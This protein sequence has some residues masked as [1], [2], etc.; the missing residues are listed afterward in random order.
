MLWFW[1]RKK[2]EFTQPSS[3]IYLFIKSNNFVKK[4]QKNFNKVKKSISNIDV[5][6][7]VYKIIISQNNQSSRSETKLIFH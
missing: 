2:K 7:R 6:F 3:P 5:N 1:I 4:I